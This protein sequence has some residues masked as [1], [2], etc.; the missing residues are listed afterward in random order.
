MKAI[1]EENKGKYKILKDILIEDLDAFIKPLREK[2]AKLEADMGYVMKVLKEGNDV[3]AS[4]AA[5]KMSEVKKI[6]GLSV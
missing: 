3:A 6:C 5:K 1:Y 4:L 2:R